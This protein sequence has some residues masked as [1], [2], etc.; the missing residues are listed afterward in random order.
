MSKVFRIEI[1]PFNARREDI[2]ESVIELGIQKKI[3]VY[4]TKIYWLKG[5]YHL[6]DIEKV[7]KEILCE[8][9]IEDYRI[10]QKYEM[11]AN[12][13]EIVYH[14]GVR[15]PVEDSVKE[16]IRLFNF[17][18]PEAVKTGRRYFIKGELTEQEVDYI[19]RKIMYNPVIERKVKV[20]EVIFAEPQCYKFELI[21]IPISSFSDEDMV[22]YSQEK[23]LA[24]NLEEM[25]AIKRYFSKK[26]RN[27]TDCE[28]ET[29][30]QT[31]SEHCVHK[32]F[33]GKYY[34]GD[35]YIDNLL[36]SYIAKVSEE[37]KKDFCLVL[38]KDNAGIIEFDEE[39]GI[40][41]KVETH[42]HPSAIEPYGGSATGIGGVIRDILG[43]GKGAEPIMNTDVFCVGPL[44]IS[45]SELP[46]GVLHPKRILKGVVAGVRD[47]GNRMGIPTC[48]GG[49][50][51]DNGYIANPLVYCGTV[52]I[53]PKKYIHKSLMPG[54]K[55]VLIGGRTG[56]DGIH[57]VTFASCELEEKSEEIS[58][59]AVQIGD[60]ITEKKV[61]DVIISARDK[62]LIEFVTDCGGGGLSSA[63]GESAEITNGV[64]VYLD[65]VPLKY[66]GL[67]YTEIWISES[68]ERMILGVKE[69]NID[70]LKEI[71]DI[72][73]CEMNVIGEYTDS[74]KLELFYEGNKVCEID[75]DFL[76]KGRPEVI[77][78]VPRVEYREED[79]NAP[80]PRDTKEILLRLLSSLNIRSRERIIRQYD[81]EVQGKSVIKPLIGH[82]KLSPQDAV[83]IKPKFNSEKKLAISNGIC[84][85]YSYISPYWM[86][87][88]AIDEAVRSLISCGV[89]PEKIALLDNFCFANPENEEVMAEI[90]EA[91]KACYK[92][93][94]AFKTPFISGKDSLYNEFKTENLRIKIPATLLVTGVGI[95]EENVTPI[96]A[97][98]KE[99]GNPVYL[100]GETKKELGASEYFRL[101]DIEKGFVPKV[102]ADKFLKVYKTL[103]KVIK[104]EFILASHD[105]SQGGLA[106][107][108]SE[109]TFARNRGVKI[110]VESDLRWDEFLFSES[111]GRILIEVKKEKKEEFEKLFEDLP[112]LFLGNVTSKPYFEIDFNN[113][114]I[115][116]LNIEDMYREF[117]KPVI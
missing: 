19:A 42:N 90:I 38:F 10:N 117:S 88:N 46:E 113:K 62:D 12:D 47:Y 8:D 3:E 75:I 108:L 57:G 1:I 94:R 107:A 60:P 45:H 23:G 102:H 56:K 105:V 52:G 92:I 112:F 69:K 86:A 89:N 39:V 71:C 77:R 2:E 114:L 51:V 99:A 87:A 29:I 100:V 111:A 7:A 110:K 72:Y 78:K 74:G 4:E 63:I 103:Y 61:L 76:H 41:V 116:K 6:N 14:F 48:A 5:D 27:P 66:K 91:C 26:K 98:F 115:V 25:R 97:C 82:L 83:V 80:E 96:T 109:M 13:F 35:E 40:A 67:S 32:T 68:Q 16:S 73:A 55:I 11:E 65:R 58:I 30:A 21:E 101:L 59:S 64:R 31:W 24:L 106:V 22:R 36:K 79:V 37:F 50:L 20:P 17:K 85:L 93:A 54:Y 34:Y 95:I 28:I 84:P 44:D 70:R 33:K 18:E 9:V 53:I 15:D 49:V 104:K 81:H 43:A